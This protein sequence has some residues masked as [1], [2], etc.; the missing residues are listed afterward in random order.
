MNR[1][2][3]D[4]VEAD[5]DPETVIAVTLQ[6]YN[7][8][9]PSSIG[10]SYSNEFELPLT[11]TNRVLLGLPD[12]KSTDQTLKA[13]I[14]IRYVEEGVEIIPSG[15]L[16]VNTVYDTKAACVI[17]ASGFDFYSY[18]KERTLN[19]LDYTDINPLI[20]GATGSHAS[21]LIYELISSAE[22]AGGDGEVFS[23]I[24]DLGNTIINNGGQIEAV[25]YDY[26][27]LPTTDNMF[28][29]LFFGYK[30]V[31]QRVI[32]Q[33]GYSY[34]WGDLTDSDKFNN[35]AI[36]Q[37]GY[38]DQ[39]RLQ[40]SESFRDD[41][42]FSA[43]TDAD[44]TVTNLGSGGTLVFWFKNEVKRSDFYYPDPVGP[45][46][47]RYLVTNADTA[48]EYFA[49]TFTYKGYV[50][51]S[52]GSGDVA[53]YFNGVKQTGAG[54]KQTLASGVNYVDISLNVNLA[55]AGTIE[56][57]FVQ[58][59]A[60]PCSITYYAGG[61]FAGT[62]MGVNEALGSAP[63]I[64]LNQILP[65]INQLDLF[66]DLLIRFGR[67]PKFANGVVS[68]ISLKDVLDDVTGVIEW[69]GKR[70]KD[71]KSYDAHVTEL[72]QINYLRYQILDSDLNDGFRQGT[73]EIDDDTLDE[74]KTFYESPFAASLDLPKEG[75]FCGK[76]D[77]Q[78]SY[79]ADDFTRWK[80]DTGARLFLTRMNYDNEPSIVIGTFPNNTPV[81]S[82][83]VACG[84]VVATSEYD[85]SIGFD[86][87]LREW[88]T[89]DGTFSTG[90]LQRLKN[91]KWVTYYYN[92]T[93]ADVYGLDPQKMI[94]DDGSLFLFPTLETF[95][96]GRLTKVTMLKI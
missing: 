51:K 95:V 37:A 15:N 2:Y 45:S 68:F 71:S 23:A 29:P 67:I 60:D 30:Q 9:N 11:N 44:E 20:T 77:I 61:E 69:T 87:T 26:T 53:F 92:L 72:G 8:L 73:F 46:R 36:M 57:R 56:V 64:Y 35:L 38:S 39:I 3:I 42:E 10:V 58:T 25:T 48:N 5:L 14:P 52:S 66:K 27:T 21:H 16:V 19:D 33:A 6:T 12:I 7:P 85:R 17:Y 50:N 49:M 80:S 65:S 88:F 54:N 4:G 55:D 63:T 47:S 91:A 40:Y 90:F 1:L 31:L 59:A 13:D 81:T 28:L 43:L 74:E 75:I 70:N 94:F 96:S 18:I 89:S 82:Y 24:V 62:C 76:I 32:E 93:S 78:E 22:V 86:L 79:S 84:G 83:V 34:D 41:V